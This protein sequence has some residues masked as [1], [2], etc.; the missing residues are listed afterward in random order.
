MKKGWMIKLLNRPLI[1]AALKSIPI[2]GDIVQNM[3]DES[4]ESPKGTFSPVAM[5]PSILRILF[6]IAL[7]FFVLRGDVSIEDAED[8]KELL[9]N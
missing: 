9:D 6:L 4:F 3:D 7:A 2:V 8:V 5:V 1:K